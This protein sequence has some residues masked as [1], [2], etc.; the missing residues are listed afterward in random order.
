MMK[1]KIPFAFTAAS[2]LCGRAAEEHVEHGHPTALGVPVQKLSCSLAYRWPYAEWAGRAG[3][4]QLLGPFA[5][6]R[7]QDA[8]DRVTELP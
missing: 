2:A 3:E 7:R 1:L 5:G 8:S 4:E 6:L